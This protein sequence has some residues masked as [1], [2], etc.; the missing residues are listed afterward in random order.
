[1]KRGNER[2]AQSRGYENGMVAILALAAGAMIFEQSSINFLIPFIK[3]ELHFNNT[4]VG[5]LVSAYWVTFA[6]SSLATGRLADSIGRRKPVFLAIIVLLALFSVLSGFAHSFSQLLGARALMGLLEG[7]ML[8]IAQSIVA[9]GSS[10]QRRGTNMGIVGSLGGTALGFFVAPLV[11]VRIAAIYGWRAGFFVVVVPSL[12][13][14]LLAARFVREPTPAGSVMPDADVAGRKTG[15]G[16][17]EALRYRNVWLCGA[18]CCFYVAYN[19]LGF[20]F[21]PLYYVAVRQMSVRQMSFLMGLVGLAAMMFSVLLPVFSDRIGRRP[22]MIVANF[23]STL[24]P[25]AALCYM[26]PVAGFA[27]FQLVGWAL[28]GTGSL[29]TGT[30]PAETVPPRS[31]STAMGLI[32]AL[33]VVGG[34]IAGPAVG[35][36]TADHGGLRVP[37]LLQAGC[38]LAAALVSAALLETAPRKAKK[39][40]GLL[41]AT[42]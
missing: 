18:I 28:S 8:P 9:L 33:G 37:I 6:I 32:V 40:D 1:M 31:V 30:I 35:G 22:V 17:I 42:E 15:G 4:Q 5:L 34:G 2:E 11:L 10:V 24:C 7:P 20:A 27:P 3:P 38:A 23:I 26:G 39:S 36:W 41:T 25:L 14:A 12:L 13:C 21:L 19:S 29:I 16:L